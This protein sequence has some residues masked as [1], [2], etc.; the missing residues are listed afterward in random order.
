MI[1][2]M[3]L[4]RSE[5]DLYRLWL[6]QQDADTL[7]MYFGMN[8]TSGFIDYLME[9]IMVDPTKHHFLVAFD[10]DQWIGVVHIADIPNGG[11]EFGFIVDPDYRQQ[12]VADRLMDEATT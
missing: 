4:P 8:V 12:G 11:A 7:R 2:T 10:H 6:K 1:A 9:R 3:F 5:Y